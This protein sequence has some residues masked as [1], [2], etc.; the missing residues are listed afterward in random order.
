LQTVERG[1]TILGLVAGNCG[2]TL[3]PETLQA[4]P[5]PGVVFRL[6]VDAPKEDL[7]VAWNP[8]AESLAV[9]SFLGS[10]PR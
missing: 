6:L 3:L 1:F 7:F 5:H 4:L 8:T 9:Q 2:V 10:L